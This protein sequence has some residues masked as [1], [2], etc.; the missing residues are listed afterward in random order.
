MHCVRSE[1]IYITR[2]SIRGSHN[3]LFPAHQS[4]IRRKSSSL[5]PIWFVE[6]YSHYFKSNLPECG[7]SC[8]VFDT[9]KKN[10]LEMIT[11]NQ[12][13]VQLIVLGLWPSRLLRRVSAMR[14]PK[15]I[16][17]FIVPFL[18]INCSLWFDVVVVPV[19]LLNRRRPRP[20]AE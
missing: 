18:I 19:T 2:Q 6:E 1:E 17:L 4:S 20:I 15:L 11:L 10:Q 13:Q 16:N 3:L 9:H 8:Q 14:V 12:N 7:I 5:S